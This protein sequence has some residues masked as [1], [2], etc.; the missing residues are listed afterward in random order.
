MLRRPSV[1]K[2]AVILWQTIEVTL[3]VVLVALALR[4]VGAGRRKWPA[5]HSLAGL[6]PHRLKSTKASFPSQFR[7]RP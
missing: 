2:G 5:H 1:A 6:R 4:V 3:G 7:S